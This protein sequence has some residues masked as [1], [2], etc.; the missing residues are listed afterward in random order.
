MERDPVAHRTHFPDT[1]RPYV[2]ERRTHLS[3][4]PRSRTQSEIPFPLPYPEPPPAP[5]PALVSPTEPPTPAPPD[6]GSDAEPPAPLQPVD[7]G[8]MS[9]TPGDGTGSALGRT[10]IRAM[11]RSRA[12]Q[13]ADAS[14]LWPCI[15]STHTWSMHLRPDLQS[16]RAARLARVT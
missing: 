14:Q 15:G 9:F 4:K 11:Q 8:W 2:V 3:R 1:Q 7:Q 10:Q 16:M 5:E 6:A 13:S 12:P